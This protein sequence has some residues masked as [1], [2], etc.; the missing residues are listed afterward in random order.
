MI[1]CIY[2]LIA[3]Y[4]DL[5]ILSYTLIT[6]ISSDLPLTFLIFSSFLLLPCFSSFSVLCF[7]HLF[8]PQIVIDQLLNGSF[9]VYDDELE[10]ALDLEDSLFG[11]YYSYLVIECLG[12]VLK[13]LYT[14][15]KKN[16]YFINRYWL[17]VWFVLL[18][19]IFKHILTHLDIKCY[20][21]SEC[22]EWLL[23]SLLKFKTHQEVFYL[24][25]RNRQF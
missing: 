5:K 4:W 11:I 25:T 22:F 13:S 15:F 20:V 16:Y 12:T 8:T 3:S 2:D 14:H 18:L 24:A 17:I 9:S 6:K 7:Y 10:I 1:L 19:Y 21:S 23:S